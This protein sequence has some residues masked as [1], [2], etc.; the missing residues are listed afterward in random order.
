MIDAA[1]PRARHTAEVRHESSTKFR[2]DSEGSAYVP[3]N[4]T[5]F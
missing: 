2:W 1:R 3:A 5:R 4:A